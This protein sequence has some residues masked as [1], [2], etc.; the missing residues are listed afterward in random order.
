MEK[1]LNFFPVDVR[2]N[3]EYGITGALRDSVV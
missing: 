1:V 2:I 3:P